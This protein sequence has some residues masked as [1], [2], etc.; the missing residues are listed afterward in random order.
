MK[1][2]LEGKLSC[3]ITLKGVISGV[4]PHYIFTA[5]VSTRRQVAN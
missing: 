3:Y 5:V 4:F 2:K 1:I